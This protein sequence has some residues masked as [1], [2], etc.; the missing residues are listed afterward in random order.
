MNNIGRRIG[1]V[2]VGLAGLAASIWGGTSGAV[3]ESLEFTLP[4][5]S[6]SA[7]DYPNPSP[8]YPPVED[9]QMDADFY[10]VDIVVVPKVALA[11]AGGASA[12]ASASLDGVN[13]YRFGLVSARS[14]GRNSS[15]SAQAIVLV[16]IADPQQRGSVVIDIEHK[17]AANVQVGG[18]V[19]LSWGV[20]PANFTSGTA[21]LDGGKVHLVIPPEDPYHQGIPY[22]G[23]IVQVERRTPEDPGLATI[24]AYFAHQHIGHTELLQD[25]YHNHDR[26]TLAVPPGAYAVKIA[27]GAQGPALVVFDPIIQANAANPDVAVTVHGAVDP[28]PWSPLFGMTAEDLA[29][30]GFNPAPFAEVG[31]LDSDADGDGIADGADNCP[32]TSNPDQADGDGDGV[33]DACDGSGHDLA[34]TAINP[35][36]T[37]AL[38]GAHPA[39]TKAIVVSIQNRSLHAETIHDAAALSRLVH[40]TVESLGACPA[41]ILTLV[42]PKKLPL[43]LKVKQKLDVQFNATFDC[44]NDPGKSAPGAGHGDFRYTASVDHAQ[45]G[46]VPDGHPED[47]VCPRSVTAPFVIDPNPD[48]KIKDKGCGAKKADGTFGDPVVTDVTV[49]P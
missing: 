14:S 40:L 17:L 16:E 39:Q 25:A 46:G 1:K 10:P 43:T 31:F 5:A 20:Y 33:G 47:D 41:P 8:G 38:T 32:N 6:A 30:E 36:A 42:P 15:A 4:F 44:A 3:A 7:T 12:Q 29:A 11:S 37:V 35:P 28:T 9:A 19:G 49:R 23:D 27:L 21:Y 26:S 18:L 34:L 24:D 48:G 45:L 13:P 22:I 2:V